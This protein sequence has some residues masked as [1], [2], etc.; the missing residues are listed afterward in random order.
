MGAAIK[1]KVGDK[2]NAWEVIEAN[3]INPETTSKAYIG[4]AVFSKCICTKCNKTIRYFRNNELKK[5]SL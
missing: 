3:V 1:T 5:A 2:Y 4:K